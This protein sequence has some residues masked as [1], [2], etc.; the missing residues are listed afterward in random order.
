[1]LAIGRAAAA[2]A[3]MLAAGVHPVAAQEVSPQACAE[4]RELIRYLVNEGA[5]V[6][7]A[8]LKNGVDQLANAI[9][10]RNAACGTPGDDSIP[11]PT[12]PVEPPPTP[13]P[14][15]T[16]V[17]RP[18]DPI[19]ETDNSATRRDACLLVTETEVGAAMKQG[20]KANESDPAGLEGF[21]QG[22][23]FNG[24]AVAYTDIMYFQANASFVYDAF[25]STAEANGV[26][27]VAGL[28]DRAFTYIG[29][30]GPGVVV[31]KGDKLFTIEFSGIGN[32]QPERDSLLVL[33][34]QA[35]GRV[36]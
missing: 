3:L 29:G 27:P 9:L 12:T 18:A 2:L 25:H 28:G 13:V 24:A 23:E 34:Q 10:V 11:A 26:Q 21:A 33:A 31:T 8:S 7:E 22:C 5:F 19:A 36:H 30:N 1:V 32:G 20:V 4:G 14:A 6:Q 35:V 15:P 17:F 16:P